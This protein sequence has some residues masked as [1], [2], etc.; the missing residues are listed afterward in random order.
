MKSSSKKNF[1]LLGWLALVGLF[2]LS[3]F[4]LS[5]RAG[6]YPS[7]KANFQT[8]WDLQTIADS[9]GDTSLGLDAFGNPHISFRDMI[10]GHP[11][12][13]YATWTGSE[14]QVETVDSGEIGYITSLAVDSNNLPHISYFDE[15]NMELKYVYWTGSSWSIQIIPDANPYKSSLELDQNDSPHISSG[16][17]VYDP[18]SVYWGY[19]D[20]ST[21]N[22]TS[23]D[24]QEIESGDFLLVGTT[25][26][27]LDSTGNPHIAYATH[28]PDFDDYKLKYA[29]WTDTGWII[30]TVY[31]SSAVWYLSLAL[32]ENDLPRIAYYD[33]VLKYAAYDGTAWDINVVD[34][35]GD[36]GHY[37]SLAFDSI[38][39][40]H[41]SYYDVTNGNLKYAFWDNGIWNIL[42]V[43]SIGD[44]GMYTSLVLDENGNPHISYYDATNLDL[45]YAI[46]TLDIPTPTHTNTPTP[47]RTITP[48]PTL[49]PSPGRNEVFLPIELKNFVNYFTG[50]W[51]IEDNDSYL[52]ANGPLHS[53]Q[54]YFG[55]PDDQKDYFSVHLSTPGTIS[56][57]LSNHSGQGAAAA[58]LSIGGQR[59][60]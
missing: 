2:V 7:A 47:T 54:D 28:R 20:Y 1:S 6:Y 52:Q 34:Q 3:S 15:Y 17:S 39:N 14:W 22:G 21:W 35:S 4:A 59:S 16:L 32:D 60:W 36:V 56:I 44:V 48:T 9:L 58:V 38:N 26:L 5:E 18:W 49:T 57:D 33:G 45:K 11:N 51:E 41:I 13:R 46:G 40:P 27:A 53:G 24:V 43:D 55:Y 19:V 25:S 37:P 31:S 23:W 12:L 42:T 29:Y 10:G 8:V 50:P 30:Q